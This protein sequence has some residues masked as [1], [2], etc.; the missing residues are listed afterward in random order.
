[1]RT[2]RFGTTG[3]SVSLL[4][5]G[6]GQVGGAEL[7]EKRASALL[8]GALD[9]GITL[10]DTARGYGL[11]EERIG[12]HV[13]HRRDSFV[14]SSKCG[15]GVPGVPDWTGACI[16]AGVDA[17]L[18]R[19]RTDRIDI[20][21]LHSCPV[22]VLESGGVVEALEAAR[23][24]G[25]VRVAAYSGENEA[26][27]WAVKSGAFQSV[28]TSVNVCDQ[29][30]L[31]DVIPDAAALGMGVIAKRPLAN[32]FWRHAERPV[33]NYCE[34]YWERAREMGLSPGGLAWDEFALRFGAFQPGVCSVIAGTA[35]LEHLRRNAE[36][37]EKGPLPAEV[38]ADVVRRFDACG[39]GWRGEV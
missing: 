5:L 26:L 34:V 21:H 20:M 6:A 1:M 22:G 29:R 36:M 3:L 7:S 17:A 8:N 9:A 13:S 38:A 33:G 15:Y 27:R 14:L 39:A 24:A 28:Q 4:G 30:S 37:I 2:G 12:R 18:K 16:V 23:R 32:G 25:K 35:S 31:R 10:I 19:L 11:S